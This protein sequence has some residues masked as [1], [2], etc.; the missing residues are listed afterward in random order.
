MDFEMRATGV[1]LP[2]NAAL[3]VG[4]AVH[5]KVHVVLSSGLEDLC[6]LGAS[7]VLAGTGCRLP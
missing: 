2:A 6:A 7:V 4:V 1:H 3:I 5:L